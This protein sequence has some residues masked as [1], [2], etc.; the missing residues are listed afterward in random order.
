[1]KS[2]LVGLVAGVLLLTTAGCG[3][4]GESDAG[5]AATSPS[6][7]AK[8]SSSPAPTYFGDAE[9]SAINDTALPA[10]DAIT[11]AH[12]A[13][14]RCDRVGSSDGY[15]AWRRCWHRLLDPAEKGLVDSSGVLTELAGKPLPP[16]CVAALEAAAK[17]LQGHARTVAAVMAGID[18]PRL[19][20]QTRAVNRMRRVLEE[21]HG[22]FG[23]RFGGLTPLCYSPED[24]KSIEAEPSQVPS[25]S[26]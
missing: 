24:L 1:M 14:A 23:K 16:R 19:G 25:E 4:D 3:S 6:A 2:V 17:A 11:K 21:A 15:P 18:S 7:S 5:S 10:Q 20:A 8:A 22:A 12:G 9:S 13:M 26:P